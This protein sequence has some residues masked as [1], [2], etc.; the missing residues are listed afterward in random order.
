MWPHH[1]FLLHHIK[2]TLFGQTGV[3][4]SSHDIANF[5][6]CNHNIHLCVQSYNHTMYIVAP[7]SPSGVFPLAPCQ[8]LYCQSVLLWSLP[9]DLKLISL[10]IISGI[11]ILNLASRKVYHTLYNV[12]SHG[13]GPSTTTT[14]TIIL[15]LL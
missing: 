1:D 3:S 8:C 14:H 12:C 15:S 7:D 9:V 6:S 2:L 4:T 11:T 10:Y 5:V 13:G